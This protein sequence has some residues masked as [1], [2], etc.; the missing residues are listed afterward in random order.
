M[1]DSAFVSARRYAGSKLLHWT[2]TGL[3]YSF[4]ALPKHQPARRGVERIANV[5]YT[6]T[7]VGTLRLD[8][9]RPI[10]RSGPL[11]VVLYIHGG[12]F[13]ILSK[14]T[15]WMFGQRFA[16]AGVDFGGGQRAAGPGQYLAEDRPVGSGRFAA[17]WKYRKNQGR[18]DSRLHASNS[19]VRPETVYAAHADPTGGIPGNEG[20]TRPPAAYVRVTGFLESPY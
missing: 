3:S 19:Q 11:P 5:A 4:R 12:G 20:R 1:A 8:V 6:E 16:Q 2:L 7:P 14:D 17:R 18:K 10:E 9:Y 15:H 13:R